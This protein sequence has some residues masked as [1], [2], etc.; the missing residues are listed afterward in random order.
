MITFT[1]TTLDGAEAY[2]FGILD[3]NKMG[4][5]IGAAPQSQAAAYQAPD[6]AT[7]SL[8]TYTKYNPG[9]EEY[10]GLQ[11]HITLVM[12]EP[13]KISWNFPSDDNF[14]LGYA[15]SYDM[16]DG[17]HYGQAPNYEYSDDSYTKGEELCYVGTRVAFYCDGFDVAFTGLEYV[18]GAEW[19]SLSAGQYTTAEAVDNYDKKTHTIYIFVMPP[20]DVTVTISAAS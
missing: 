12:E 13:H 20:H 15:G 9:N 11:E 19:T 5:T 2:S 7:T 17:I 14:S 6:G 8:G 16:A 3:S 10:Q 4:I 1:V 18:A